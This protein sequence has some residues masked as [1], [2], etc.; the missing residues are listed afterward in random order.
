MK[1]KR[2]FILLIACLLIA[3]SLAAPAEAVAVNASNAQAIT[4][5]TNRVEVSISAHVLATLSDSVSLDNGEVVSYD[6]TY[7]PRNASIKFGYIAPDGYFYG[8]SG[9]DGS[10]YKSIRVSKPGSYTLAIWNKSDEAVTVTG[11]VNY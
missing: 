4:R 1:V 2:V 7:T 9:S 3:G 8:L 5:V 11:T 6:C 10:I